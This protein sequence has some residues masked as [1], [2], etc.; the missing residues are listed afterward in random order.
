MPVAACAQTPVLRWAFDGPGPKAGAP[1]T[2]TWISGGVLRIDGGGSGYA[3]FQ[4]SGGAGPATPGVF[5]G[6][7][8]LYGDLQGAALAGSAASPLRTKRDWCTATSSRPT[9]CSA[10]TSAD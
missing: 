9:S 1:V 6:A 8:N 7:A 10:A 5:N 2:S 3:M 4:P